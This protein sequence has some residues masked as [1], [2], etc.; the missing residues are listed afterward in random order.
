M[1]RTAWVTKP[2]SAPDGI[3]QPEEDR[4]AAFVFGVLEGGHVERLLASA[5]PRAKVRVPPAGS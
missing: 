1:L 4:L 5:R 3:G 2:S